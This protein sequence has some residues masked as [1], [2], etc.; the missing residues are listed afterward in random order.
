MSNFLL[1]GGDGKT[2]G[3]SLLTCKYIFQKYEHHKFES[4]PQA[5]LD[6][7]VWEKIQQKVL[8]KKVL[9]GPR[10]CERIYP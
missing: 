1:P 6:I 9:K 8:R 3:E 7:H 4:F 5:W 10:K 2:L